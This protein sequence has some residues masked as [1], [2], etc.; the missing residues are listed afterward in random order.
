M[1][2]KEK[3]IIRQ[4]ADY[5]EKG[6]EGK[7][8]ITGR[9]ESKDNGGVCAMGACY[10]GA[11]VFK[12]RDVWFIVE[13]KKVL[14]ID[15]MPLVTYPSDAKHWN[16]IDKP[17]SVRIDDAIISLNDVAGWRFDQI[18]SWLRSIAE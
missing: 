14:K 18:V 16:W 8:Q 4:M 7:Q 9:Y 17:E 15:F 1:D 2:I 10:I 11:G 12:Y 3:Q 6:A 5:I 13:L